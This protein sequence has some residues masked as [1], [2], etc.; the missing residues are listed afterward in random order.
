VTD[1]PGTSTT[2]HALAVRW[3]PRELARQLR[4]MLPAGHAVDDADW[5]FRHRCIVAVVGLEFLVIAVVLVAVHHEPLTAVAEL[6]GV[7]VFL[8]AACLRIGRT[9]RQLASS[10]GLMAAAGVFVHLAD[11]LTEV[12]FAFFVSLGLVI[13]Y[14]D[15]VPFFGAVLFVLVQHSLGG[16]F[17]PHS[18]F[19]HP[20]ALDH[21]WRW[22][23]LHGVFLLAS[24]AASLASWSIMERSL[25]RDALTRLPSRYRLV[26]EISRARGRGTV[27]VIDLDDF[28]RLNDSLG[29]EQANALLRAVADRLVASVDRGVLVS[30]LAAD[31]FGILFPEEV[32]DWVVDSIQEDLRRAFEVG[33]DELHLTASIGFTTLDVD[34]D[35]ETALLHARMALRAAKGEGKSRSRRFTPTLGAQASRRNQLLAD[36]EGADERGELR[37]LYQPVIDL[38]T[39]RTVGAEALMRWEHPTLGRIGPDQFI[40]LAEQS[41]LIVPMGQ[42][43]MRTA[44]A[45]LRRWHEVAGDHARLTMAVNVTW[46]ELARERYLDELGELLQQSGVDA[47]HVVVEMTETDIMRDPVLAL[48]RVQGLRDLGLTVA[49]DDFGTGYSSLDQ[50]CRLPMQIVKVDRSFTARVPDDHDGTL[51]AQTLANLALALGRTVVIEGIEDTDQE[52]FF[53]SIGDFHAQGYLYARPLEAPDFEARLTAEAAADAADAADADAADAAAEAAPAPIGQAVDGV[54]RRALVV[55]DEPSHSAAL[56]RLLARHGIESV[57]T[58]TLAEAEAGLAEPVDAA[59]VDLRLDGA[60]GWQLIARLRQ[61]PTVRPCPIVVVSGLGDPA[62]QARALANRCAHVTKPCRW[63]DLADALRRAVVMVGQGDDAPV[64]LPVGPG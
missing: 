40:P 21:P 25:T 7:G 1:P 50:L 15:W 24:G 54:I 38:R 46:Q 10:L 63:D 30:R 55:D 26:D 44:L 39:L 6:G 51:V 53:R 14:Q 42:W 57:V 56:R 12:H 2:R 49:L 35:P 41:G 29:Y 45:Q 11:G 36:L 48:A 8:A 9:V 20:S 4:A 19:D 22:A 47:E 62:T 64:G 32:G 13:L 60:D 52:L 37:L 58:N 43:A 23:A 31:S 59:F 28:G 61:Q 17:A 27:A 33:G 16:V 34:R 3:R 5:R 18:V